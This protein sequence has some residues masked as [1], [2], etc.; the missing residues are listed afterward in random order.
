VAGRAVNAQDGWQLALFVALPYV[1]LAVFVVGHIWRYR[2]DRFGWTSRSSEL[3]ERRLLLVGGPLFHYGTLLAI[4]GHAAG[5]L[6]PKAWTEA[7][8]VPESLYVTFA[9]LGGSLAAVLVVAGL[10]VLSVRRAGND[11]VR[12]VTSALDWAAIALLWVMVALGVAVTVGYQ[13]LGP[14]YDY[15]ETVSVWL[16]G[17]FALHPDVAGMAAA[18]LI[19]RVHVTVAWLF[20][21]LF[22]FTRFVHFWSAPV[23]YLARP[24]L[25]YRRRRRQ[26]ALSPGEAHEWR[27]F[28]RLSRGP[29]L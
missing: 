14:G 2:F 6:V 19:F 28:A 21:A 9:K 4:L 10:L 17:V 29:R 18:P 1:A 5:L 25:V 23:W 22:P 16:R 13:D 20:L 27:T 11:R 3:Y 26:L 15:R 7:L 8:G 24:F 12:R